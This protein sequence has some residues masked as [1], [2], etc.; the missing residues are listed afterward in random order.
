M[1]VRVSTVILL[2]VN[3]K[4]A[5]LMATDRDVG[6]RIEYST[7]TLPANMDL[8]VIDSGPTKVSRFARAV[9]NCVIKAL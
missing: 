8:T 4:M 5:E 9:R 6:T 2:G 1:A 3:A 7:T